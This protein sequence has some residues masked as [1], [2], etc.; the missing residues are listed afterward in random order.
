MGNIWSNLVI[1]YGRSDFSTETRYERFSD[2]ESYYQ[3]LEEKIQSIKETLWKMAQD[4]NWK[5]TFV[6]SQTDQVISRELVKEDFDNIQYS[7]L[8]VN[9]NRKCDF[10]A[11]GK[12]V[13]DGNQSNNC[14]KM[15]KLTDSLDYE[16]TPARAR[17][18]YNPFGQNGIIASSSNDDHPFAVEE[19]KWVFIFYLASHVI[20]TCNFK[21][22]KHLKSSITSIK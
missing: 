19:D 12:I 3:E 7:A 1:I 18:S 22:L 21:D 15:A 2:G 20:H 14:W 17:R 8:N 16:S 6:D 4:G 9:Q 13:T 10:G 5:K 11:D